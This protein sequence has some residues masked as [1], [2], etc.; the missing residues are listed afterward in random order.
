METYSYTEHAAQR[1]EELSD[2]EPRLSTS[3]RVDAWLAE[4]FNDLYRVAV[5][6]RLGHDARAR[7]DAREQFQ[8]QLQEVAR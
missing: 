7:R 5:H 2:G 1:R 4:V 3:A 8:A 6:Q